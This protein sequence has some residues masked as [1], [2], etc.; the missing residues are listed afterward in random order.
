MKNWVKLPCLSAQVEADLGGMGRY[1]SLAG[2]EFAPPFVRGAR[3]EGG[4]S[5]A[6]RGKPGKSNDPHPISAN[7]FKFRFPETT[8]G[9]PALPPAL[10]PFLFFVPPGW[11]SA[12]P[13]HP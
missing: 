13:D 7:P 12:A 11:R 3:I 5:S 1:L 6:P 8:Q 10:M 9:E 4:A 2:A